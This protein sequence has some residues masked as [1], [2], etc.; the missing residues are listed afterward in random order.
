MQRIQIISNNPLIVFCADDC[1]VSAESVLPVLLK[2]RDLVHLG[3]HLL[4]H[5]LAGSLKPNENPYRS[6]VVTK[7]ALGV[8]Y[9]SV[10]LVEGAIAVSRRM[11]SE[12]PYRAWSRAVLADL[13]LVDK[14]LLASALESL[15]KDIS[16]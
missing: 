4:T 8:D 16:I 9:Q 15:G 1:F 13:Q 2:V 5:P 3:H 6:V 10:Q 14:A 11:L 7:E 12:K